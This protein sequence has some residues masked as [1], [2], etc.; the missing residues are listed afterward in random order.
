MA[1]N[2][3]TALALDLGNVLVKVDH[4]RFCRRLAA[5]AGLSTE[6]VYAR[7]FE[8]DLEPGYDTGRLTSEEFHRRVMQHFGVILPFSQFS[9]WWNDIFDPM[10][11]MAELVGYLSARFPLYLL[12]NTNTLHFS[13]IRENYSFLDLF[14]SFV[15]SFEVGSRKPEPAIYRALIQQTGR[16]ASQCLFV[17]DK[18]PFVTAAREQGLVSW[19]FTS[20]LE[21]I[22]CLQRHGLY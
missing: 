17:D 22:G 9:S 10:E 6:E 8:S 15:L 5:L 7:V 11:G 12:S 1:S 13:Y 21:F 3:I 19:Q 2:N 18:L 4:L 20:P 16:P 14:E